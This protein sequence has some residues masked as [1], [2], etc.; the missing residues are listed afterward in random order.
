[1]K[2]NSDVVTTI[3]GLVSAITIAGQ[4]AIAAYH[5]GTINWFNVAGAVVIAA[6][7]YFTNKKTA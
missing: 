7:G 6:F 2:F 3:L 4:Q 1:M 5:G